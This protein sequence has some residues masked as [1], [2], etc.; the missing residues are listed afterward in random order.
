MSY[1][2]D[3]ILNNYVLDVSQED[4]DHESLASAVTLGR[5]D[6]L[7]DDELHIRFS[8]RVYDSWRDKLGWE[9]DDFS[10]QLSL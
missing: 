2:L 6:E 7:V 9:W 5:T 10:H 3:K 4:S 1:L 8:S